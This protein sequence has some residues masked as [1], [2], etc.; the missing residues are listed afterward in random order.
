M[1]SIPNIIFEGE[2]YAY[3]DCIAYKFDRSLSSTLSSPL[4]KLA[5]AVDDITTAWVKIALLPKGIKWNP[6][7]KE[8][9]PDFYA[10]FECEE[11]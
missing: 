8:L 9:E 11:N 3:R 5:A 4:G 1:A 10:I 7:S 6:V 2:L